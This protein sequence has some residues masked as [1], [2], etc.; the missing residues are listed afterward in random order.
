MLVPMQVSPWLGSMLCRGVSAASGCAGSPPWPHQPPTSWSGSGCPWSPA[1]AAPA[2][3]WSVT[4]PPPQP[5]SMVKGAAGGPCMAWGRRVA[6][7]G[8]RGCPQPPLCSV[9][10]GIEPFQRYNISVYPLYS[11]AVGV[12][13]HTTAYSKQKGTCVPSSARGA[14]GPPPA[15]ASLCL[16]KRRVGQFRGCAKELR[17]LG[18]ILAPL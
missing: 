17:P 14:P 3:R 12:P 11:D 13:V 5:S 16:S 9:A 4:G 1:A 8:N 18:W 10:D 7:W 6:P 2:G 15:P